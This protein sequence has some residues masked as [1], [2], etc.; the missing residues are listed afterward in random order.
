[1]IGFAYAMIV[2]PFL[3]QEVI[4]SAGQSGLWVGCRAGQRESSVTAVA[5][6]SAAAA[7]NAATAW[8]CPAGTW[9]AT[10]RTREW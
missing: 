8:R 2:P 4:R 3:G 7:R 10:A 1:M 5:A 6:A 9:A